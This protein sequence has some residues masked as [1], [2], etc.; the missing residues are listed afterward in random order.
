MGMQVI[1]KYSGEVEIFWV[2]GGSPD[3]QKRKEI[4]THT[5]IYI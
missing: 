5:S 2:G 3:K 1:M 4:Y